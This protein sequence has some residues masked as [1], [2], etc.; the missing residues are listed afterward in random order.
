MFGSRKKRATG[1]HIGDDALNVVE[2]SS[3]SREGAKIEGLVSLDLDRWP[4][5]VR[6][7]RDD[8]SHQ[9]LEALR[10]SVDEYDLNFPSPLVALDPSLV[11]VKRRALIPGSDKENR[12]YL[13]WEATQFLSDDLD[14]YLLDFLLTTQFGFVVAVRR[15]AVEKL[16]SLCKDAGVAK[17]RF[18][19]VPFALCNALEFSGGS[20]EGV[21]LVI[22]IGDT[23]ARLVLLNKGELQALESC[24]WWDGG[25]AMY[26]DAFSYSPGSKQDTGGKDFG[27][28]RVANHA[29]D[30]RSQ[31]QLLSAALAGFVDR[32]ADGKTPDR[33]W[34]AGR[35]AD[36]PQWGAAVASTL[37]IP[38]ESL[39]PFAAVEGSEEIVTNVNAPA[40]AVAAGLA[41][42][43]LAGD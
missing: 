19:A 27:K 33:V 17:P 20:L 7:S 9:L 25:F 37:S 11:S 24:N 36:S 29:S 39:N 1:I 15:V 28:D 16:R 6:L 14:H 35:D 32:W 13:K 31:A 18:D 26:M 23:E 2:M 34:I 41:F 21:D 43:G 4:L 3:S 42:R 12:E 5:S 30:D 40:F 10:R 8:V 22:D 38:G